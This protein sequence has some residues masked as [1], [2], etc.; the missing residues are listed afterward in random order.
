MIIIK[1]FNPQ[2]VDAYSEQGNTFVNLGFETAEQ[3]QLFY[4]AMSDA[5]LKGAVVLGN[6]HVIINVDEIVTI[7]T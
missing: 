2:T 7:Q 6:T 1:D 5:Q 3:A 4:A